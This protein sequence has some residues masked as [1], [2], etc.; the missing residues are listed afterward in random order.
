MI[1]SNSFVLNMGDLGVMNRCLIKCLSS[2]N[3]YCDYHFITNNTPL[4]W[5]KVRYTGSI[6]FDNGFG[7]MTRGQ[8]WIGYDE[9]IR[10]LFSYNKII[11]PYQDPVLLDVIYTV[12]LLD[13]FP[14]TDYKQPLMTLSTSLPDCVKTCLN[15][16]ECKGITRP[17]EVTFGV[18]YCHLKS[19]I[20]FINNNSSLYNSFNVQTIT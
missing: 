18:G 11:L 6:S 3:G 5:I 19:N 7:L 1:P 14:N 13:Y 15:M 10:G 17:K 12:K 16:P 8:Q 9:V 4:P 2:Y 20:T